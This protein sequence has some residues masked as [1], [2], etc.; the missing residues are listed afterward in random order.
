MCRMPVCFRH[1]RKVAVVALLAAMLVQGS[2]LLWFPGW[3]VI[4]PSFLMYS[5][6]RWHTHA[7]R[8]YPG[9]VSWAVVGDGTESEAFRARLEELRGENTVEFCGWLEGNGL[10]DAYRCSD[11]VYAPGR[12]ALEAM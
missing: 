4:K 11:F 3:I 1:R 12:C 10:R 6:M 2:E 7:A 8:A 5:R 9:R